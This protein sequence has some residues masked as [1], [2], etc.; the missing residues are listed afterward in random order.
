[1][2]ST[3]LIMRLPLH[4]YFLPRFFARLFIA[5]AKF[6][7]SRQCARDYSTLGRAKTS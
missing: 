4:S 2:C 3:Y 7:F 6:V 5:Y 1:M